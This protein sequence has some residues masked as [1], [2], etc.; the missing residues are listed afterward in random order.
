MNPQT[1]NR[2]FRSFSLQTIGR[3]IPLIVLPAI[4]AGLVVG[5]LARGESGPVVARQ[6]MA[7][8]NVGWSDLAS[9]HEANIAWLERNRDSLVGS[10]DVEV[11]VVPPEN[12]QLSLFSIEAESL[13]EDE[14]VQALATVTEA[15]T[16]DIDPFGDR[17]AE[18]QQIQAELDSATERVVQ[19]RADLEALQ[20]QRAEAVA[21]DEENLVRE[22]ERESVLAEVRLQQW[23]QRTNQL[24][25]QI[26]ELTAQAGSS[27][28]AIGELEVRPPTVATSGRIAGILTTFVVG[29]AAVFAL[30]TYARLFGRIRNEAHL[31]LL[32]PEVPVVRVSDAEAAPSVAF[33]TKLITTDASD[34]V[35]TILDVS[36]KEGGRRLASMLQATLDRM[37]VAVYY[38]ETNTHFDQIEQA[39]HRT[40]HARPIVISPKF[41]GQTLAATVALCSDVILVTTAGDTKAQEFTRALNN[42]ERLQVTPLASVLIAADLKYGDFNGEPGYETWDGESQNGLSFNPRQTY[43]L[44]DLLR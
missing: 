41:T 40:N 21:Q 20:E 35:I 31:S 27:N 23:D 42:V 19:F 6:A 18:T 34:G 25:L 39:V 11:V 4:F 26:T 33:L 22:L 30:L 1:Y 13:N 24:E 17:E 37:A 8:R 5:F 9:T 3:N 36:E 28:Q 10:L 38:P 2:R 43:E 12:R 14:A 29:L 44:S 15:M 7:L 16:S 32:A